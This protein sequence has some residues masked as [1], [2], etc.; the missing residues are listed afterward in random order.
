MSK[1]KFGVSSYS[2]HRA[3]VSGQLTPI[4]A[5]QWVADRGGEHMEVVPSGFRLENNP[6]LLE[7]I[8]EK[9]AKVDI[10][11]S[12]YSIGAN[13]VASSREEADREIEAVMRQVDTAA[14]LGVKRM[15]HDVAS[16]PLDQIGIEQFERDLEV[17]VP[18]CRQI[19]DY[20]AQFGITTSVENHGY[21]VQGSDRVIRLVRAV[22]RPNYKLTLDVGNYMCTDEDAAA[23][24]KK[25]IALASVIHLK[26]FY[27]RPSYRNPGEGWFRTLAGNY[28]R[29]AIV[30]Q[31]DIDM[32]EVIRTIQRSGYEGYITIEFEGLEDCLE[33]TRI[34]LENARRLW[35]EAL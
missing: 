16:R 35:E 5:V 2:L 19:A 24:V 3:I 22:D 12:G 31:G 21:H 7:A 27:L 18:A 14:R 8:V 10:E 32:P 20:A 13:F 4:D 26:D 9:A 23:A 11:F 28:L 6:D 33:G 29:G 25:T 1:V 17:I 15:R 34:G 30:G